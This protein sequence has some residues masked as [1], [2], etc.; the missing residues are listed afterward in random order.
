MTTLR[1]GLRGFDGLAWCGL[2]LPQVAGARSRDSTA[3]SRRHPTRIVIYRHKMRARTARQEGPCKV[4]SRRRGRGPCGRHNGTSK[5]NPSTQKSDQGRRNKVAGETTT[6]TNICR[7]A[8]AWPLDASYDRWLHGRG[9]EDTLHK[10]GDGS[11]W[12]KKP[13]K[14]CGTHRGSKRPGL[15]WRATP[16]FGCCSPPIMR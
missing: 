9:I 2:A 13:R 14:A 10:Q 11:R 12:S 7:T 3:G 16:R 4:S 6:P 1:S 5:N 8:D 15:E